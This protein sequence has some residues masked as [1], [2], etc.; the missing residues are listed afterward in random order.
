MVVASTRGSDAT[1]TAGVD[2]GA[3]VTL[4]VRLRFAGRGVAAIGPG[5][6]EEDEGWREVDKR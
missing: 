3:T 5:V 6:I 1:S 4:S 2:C